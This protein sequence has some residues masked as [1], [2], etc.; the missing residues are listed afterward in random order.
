MIMPHIHIIIDQ[1]NSSHAWSLLVSERVYIIVGI[2]LNKQSRK[3]KTETKS[4]S[5]INARFIF[6]NAPS[7]SK[8]D[9]FFWSLGLADEVAMELVTSACHCPSLM[10][11]M[12]N[13]VKFPHI[14]KWSTVHNSQEVLAWNGAGE[15]LSELQQESHIYI[16]HGI[17]RS[18]V[19]E[20]TQKD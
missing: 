8:R 12:I 15:H 7:N 20:H 4:K 1:G 2:A 5:L 13:F 18:C 14:F 3:L 11:D 9:W 6:L 19:R 16:L 10:T 17:R